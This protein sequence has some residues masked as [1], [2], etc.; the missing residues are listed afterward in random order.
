DKHALA[1]WGETIIKEFVREAVDEALRFEAALARLRTP[2]MIGLL[3]Y[4]PIRQTVEGEPLEIFPFLASS[5]LD[6]P[7]TPS[8]SPFSLPAPAPA[9]RVAL[10]AGPSPGGPS[11]RPRWRG[12]WGRLRLARRSG[13]SKCRPHPRRQANRRRRRRPQALPA[14]A[15]PPTPSRPEVRWKP[16]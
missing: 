7:T 2:H 8:P 9:T 5:R 10:R 16:P 3:H 13:C 4:S 11:T 15:A 6:D 14:G 1:P 12:R